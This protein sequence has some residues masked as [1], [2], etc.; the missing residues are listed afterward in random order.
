MVEAGPKQSSF[1]TG[2]RMGVGDVTNHFWVAGEPFFS[3]TVMVAVP[4][5][6]AASGRLLT[7]LDIFD[8]EGTKVNSVEV[9]SPAN[10]VSVVQLEPFIGALKMQAGIRHGRLAVTS[11]QGSRQLCRHGLGPEISLIHEPLV[12]RSRESCFVP[13]VI[14]GQRQHLVALVNSSH[15][16]AQLSLRLFYAQRSPEWSIS[17]PAQG[18]RVVM[19]ESELLTDADDRAWEKGPIQAYIRLSARHQTYFTCQIFEQVP[20]E[21]VEH[22]TF[23]CVT[24]W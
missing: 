13:I 22:D 20:G 21:R 8:S 16:T 24:S 18:S 19:L 15:E 1:Q 23:R 10:E 14:G 3:T 17:I 4:D 6:T 12:V 5:P 11:P 9:E 2:V 7:V